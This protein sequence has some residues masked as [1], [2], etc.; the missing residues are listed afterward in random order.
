MDI[1]VLRYFLTVAR[2]E[3]ISN[4]AKSLHVTQPTLSRQLMELESDLGIKLFLRSSGNRTI[5]LTEEGMLLRK[6]AEEIL[7][8]VEK[9][10]SELMA[11]GESISGNI[12]IGSG[13]THVISLLSKEI[14]GIREEHPDIHFHFFSG[15]ADNVTERLDHGLI[16]FGVL[17]EPS[18]IS[19]YN[20][21]F[22]PA[23]DTWGL[24]MRKDHPL[25]EKESIEASDLWD[26]PLINSSQ[27][28][29]SNAFS[30][31]LKDD[32]E[33]LN[34]V[35]TYTLLYNASLLVKDN[36]GC[37]L[38]LDKI[39]STSEDSE[40]CFRPL[41]PKLEARWHIVWKKYQVFSKP[42]EFFLNKL[43][44]AFIGK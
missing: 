42:S 38:C 6:R 41:I 34:L 23:T 15:N 27:R 31:W 25:A 17:A 21:I 2:E 11:P 37:A 22:L 43:Q 36:I 4:A 12:H 14:K 1:R 3:N 40:L 7:D 16:D 8:L 35:A 24:L 28:L 10:E 20:S 5:T 39:I 29:T 33:K 44:E 13:E 26:I 32:Y 19:K 9:T 18:N 30:K